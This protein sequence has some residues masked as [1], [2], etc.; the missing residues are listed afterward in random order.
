MESWNGTCMVTNLPILA[1]DPV[2]TQIIAVAPFADPLKSAAD[3]D[4]PHDRFVPVGWPFRARYNDYGYVEGI[5]EDVY[6]NDTLDYLRKR[7]IER[8]LGEN[9]YHDHEVTKGELGWHSLDNWLHGKRVLMTNPIGGM[10][11]K[12]LPR[13]RSV[14]LVMIHASVYKAMAAYR[15]GWERDDPEEVIRET[16]TAPKD[17]LGEFV[18]R[19]KISRYVR[20]R[21]MNNP[22]DLQDADPEETARRLAEM[23]HFDAALNLSRKQWMPMSGAGS[24]SEEWDLF[25]RIAEIGE[26]II[27]KREEELKEDDD[28]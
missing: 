28:E 19:D 26:M 7:L 2:I 8:P 25:R 4:Y 6:T 22:L 18:L 11:G 15:N 24:Q 27:E 17:G 12:E 3:S 9:K 5:E 23:V 14:G 13:E 20:D 10:M 16:L 1:G 21:E